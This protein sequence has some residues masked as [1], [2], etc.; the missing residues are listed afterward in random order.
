MKARAGREQQ[1]PGRDAGR[2]RI[3]GSERDVSLNE[4]E[5]DSVL[6]RTLIVENAADVEYRQIRVAGEVVGEPVLEASQRIDVKRECG[7]DVIGVIIGFR[8]IIH[9]VRREQHSARVDQRAGADEPIRAEELTNAPEL[10]VIVDNC[11]GI[12]GFIRDNS[13]RRGGE[14]GH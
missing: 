8:A 3:Q 9:A 10:I 12:S 1:R 13:H 5:T 4:A 11:F 7:R 14:N 6:Q 2:R